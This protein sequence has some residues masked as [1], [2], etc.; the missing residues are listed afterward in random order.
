[1]L[2]CSMGTVQV[3]PAIPAAKARRAG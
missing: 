3:L 1:V 2:A